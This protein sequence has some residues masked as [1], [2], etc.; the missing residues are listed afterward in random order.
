MENNETKDF[1]IDNMKKFKTLSVVSGI[2]FAVFF[3]MAVVFYILSHN[4]RLSY[5]VVQVTV[6]SVYTKNPLSK[7]DED[8]V[9]VEYNGK[10]YEVENLRTNE[11]LKYHTHLESQKPA[12]A[13][14]ANGKIY[15]N[16]EGIR[17]TS[18]IGTIYFVFLFG[19]LI[20]IFTTAVLIGC[21]IEAKKRE[22]GIYPAKYV[23]KHGPF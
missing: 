20:L 16:V 6:V 22:K 11:T 14:F 2:L 17:S 15:A 9:V 19:T 1:Y 21:L 4:Q 8:K 5:E 12:D 7:M 3:L 10:N 23:D 18:V 13:Y